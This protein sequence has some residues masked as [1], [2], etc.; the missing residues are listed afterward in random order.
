MLSIGGGTLRRLTIAFGVDRS[1][2]GCFV[3]ARTSSRRLV[4]PVAG[5]HRKALRRD[6][7]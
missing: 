5:C 4:R 7:G 3:E 2:A 6:L 1:Q